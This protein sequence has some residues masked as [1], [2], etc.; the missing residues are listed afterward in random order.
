MFVSQTF[1]ATVEDCK[2]LYYL[3]I[4]QAGAVMYLV[5]KNSL[6]AF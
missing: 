5:M 4:G 3:F 6:K 1:S 2:Q